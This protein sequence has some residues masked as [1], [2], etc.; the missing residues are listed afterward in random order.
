MDALYKFLVKNKDFRT[1]YKKPLKYKRAPSYADMGKNSYFV[2]EDP[3]E[4]VTRI[5]GKVETTNTTRSGDFIICGP[6]LEKYIVRPG[7]L[8]KL[9]NVQDEVL[10]PRSEPRQAAEITKKLFE[11]FKL[12]VEGA[13]FTASWGEKMLLM[14]GD[15]LVNEGNGKMYRIER[16]AFAAT[17]THRHRG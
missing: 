7:K 12:P 14:P 11:Q 8:V 6:L 1:V 10:I 5:G 4:V 17:Y 13:Q 15:Y 16:N 3:V 9:Y 2:A